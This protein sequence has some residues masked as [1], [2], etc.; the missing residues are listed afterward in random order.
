[1]NIVEVSG[2]NRD[3]FASGSSE[4]ILSIDHLTV[5]YPAKRTHILRPL[6][7]TSVV[8]DVSVQLQHGETIGIVGESG[9]GKSTLARAVLGLVPIRSGSV[10]ACGR[11]VDNSAGRR[12]SKHHRDVQMIFQDPYSSLYPR[13]DVH[14]ILREPYAIHGQL[15]GVEAKI[16]LLLDQVSLPL[17]L[18][19][20]KP[21]QL[22]GGQA[23][24]VAI[25]RAL[26]LAPKILVCDEPTSALDVTVQAQIIDLLIEVQR[27]AQISFLFI[28]HDLAVVRQIAQR[29]LVMYNGQVVEEGNVD[30]ILER[31]VHPYTMA[32]ISAAPIPD[33]KLERAKTRINIPDQIST[34]VGGCKFRE[35][36]WR[37]K[38]LGEPSVCAVK[39]PR[40]EVVQAGHAAAC[41][42]PALTPF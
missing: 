7:W 28:S 3:E 32:L 19:S 12:P 17:E 14:T 2:A 22:S 1:M 18:K 8:D 25:A 36:C 39:Q 35:R 9:S 29:V 24:R 31:P 15:L 42:F 27:K 40:A 5:A 10:L 33:P 6:V 30:T 26:A 11:K 4:A 16:D 34:V 37:W 23:Q 38:Q 20:R 21:R 41:H 13:H